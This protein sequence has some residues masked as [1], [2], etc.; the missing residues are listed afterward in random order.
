MTEIEI[1]RD[2]IFKDIFKKIVI[3]TCIIPCINHALNNLNRV[4]RVWTIS[5]V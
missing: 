4:I 1:E 2:Y 3:R 5:G